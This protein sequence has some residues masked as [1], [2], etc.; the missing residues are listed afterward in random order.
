MCKRLMSVIIAAT[1]VFTTL[2]VFNVGAAPAEYEPGTGSAGK[3]DVL[4]EQAGSYP[5]DFADSSDNVYVQ[6]NTSV[7]LENLTAGLSSVSWARQQGAI[8]NSQLILFWGDDVYAYSD[9]Y[10]LMLVFTLKQD[11]SY[12]E[13]WKYETDIV[14]GTTKE[15]WDQKILLS[16]RKLNSRLENSGLVLKTGID[17]TDPTKFDFEI[18]G[19]VIQVNVADIKR[20]NTTDQNNGVISNF[21]AAY[22]GV[23]GWGESDANP[24]EFTLKSIVDKNMGFYNEKP[25]AVSGRSAGM[26]R[27]SSTGTMQDMGTAGFKFTLVGRQRY[28]N[29]AYAPVR[30]MNGTTYTITNIVPSREATSEVSGQSAVMSIG[31]MAGKWGEDTISARVSKAKLSVVSQKAGMAEV[32]EG[33]AD[34]DVPLTDNAEIKTSLDVDGNLVISVGNKSVSV[35][36]ARLTELGINPAGA[37]LSFGMN[38]TTGLTCS[39]N[40]NVI[41]M[42]AGGFVPTADKYLIYPPAPGEILGQY[43]NGAG[44]TETVNGTPI[45]ASDSRVASKSTY[46]FDDFSM[47]I[48]NIDYLTSDSIMVCFGLVANAWCDRQ[49]VMLSFGRDGNVVVYTGVPG[50][51]AWDRPIKTVSGFDFSGGFIEFSIKLSGESYIFT[52]N[53]RTFTIPVSAFDDV[54]TNQSTEHPGFNPAACRLVFGFTSGKPASYNIRNIT[55]G[56][57]GSTGGFVQPITAGGFTPSVI[58]SKNVPSDNEIQRAQWYNET[59]VAVT[60]EA[61]GTKLDIISGRAGTVHTFNMND[62]SCIINGISFPDGGAAT[63]AIVSGFV[64]NKDAGYD[65]AAFLLRFNKNGVLELLCGRELSFPK[66]PVLSYSGFDFTSV[67]EFGMKLNGDIYTLTVNGYDIEF[68][69]FVLNG[70]VTGTAPVLNPQAA[71]LLFMKTTTDA[72]AKVSFNVANFTGGQPGSTGFVGK[73]GPFTPTDPSAFTN[74]PAD[75]E[76][77]P[78]WNANI[79]VDALSSGTTLTFV[80]GN[81][82]TGSEHT[83]NINDFSMAIRNITWSAGAVDNDAIMIGFGVS[84]TSGYDTAS[85]LL[86]FTKGGQV[87]ISAGA[88]AGQIPAAFKTVSGFDFSGGVVEFSIKLSGS[89]YI[90]IVNGFEM[91]FDKTEFAVVMSDVMPLNPEA[92]YIFCMGFKAGTSF[93]ICNITGGQPGSTGGFELYPDPVQ[94]QNPFVPTPESGMTNKPAAGDILRPDFI[95]AEM[96]KIDGNIVTFTTLGGSRTGSSYDYNCNDFSIIFDNLVYGAEAGTNPAV[97]VGISGSSGGWTDSPG[98]FLHL[99]K[100]GRIVFYKSANT[101]NQPKKFRTDARLTGTMLDS[102][103]ELAL[104]LNGSTYTL[105]I[106]GWTVDFDKSLIADVLAAGLDMTRANVSLGVS[107]KDMSFTVANFTGKNTALLDLPDDNFTPTDKAGLQNHP[108]EG[109]IEV[110]YSTGIEV[111]TPSKSGTRLTFMDATPASSRAGTK[112]TYNMNELHLV[113]NKIEYETNRT[114]I[115]VAVTA[116]PNGWTDAYTIRFLFSRDGKVTVSK[117]HPAGVGGNKTIIDQYQLDTNFG[118]I[119]EFRFKLVGNEY[120]MTANGQTLKIPKADLDSTIFTPDGLDMTSAYLS[121][122]VSGQLGN[123]SYNIF[124]ITGGGPDATS[125]FEGEDIEDDEEEEETPKA[126]AGNTQEEDDGDDGAAAGNTGENAGNTGNETIGD[127]DNDG[128]VAGAQTVEEP[129]RTIIRKTN[130]MAVYIIMGVV[131]LAAVGAAVV[132]ILKFGRKP[133]PEAAPTAG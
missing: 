99:Y 1:L 30:S 76:H 3:V 69:A 130:Y 105:S 75:G 89:E 109:E 119:L 2:F 50:H 124:N 113:I 6:K 73:P 112:S 15:P 96:L 114:G 92:A 86:R 84:K 32:A 5:L 17:A 65:N 23:S 128:N 44:P 63:D 48:N 52:V 125:N 85:F 26:S 29:N 57:T 127:G 34:F 94:V 9:A 36:N 40:L 27:I 43:G 42:P 108:A 72:S 18:N 12:A 24:I 13:I 122:G 68:P 38:G 91:K 53:S 49:S 111:G 61:T 4:A 131:A 33:S 120:V 16:S 47:V 66:N 101:S 14:S 11:G 97:I 81:G 7:R 58:Y 106:N 74:P 77:L 35:L 107:P 39:Y 133:K 104:K 82:R 41:D 54:K 20:P 62:M 37:Y 31:G 21:D 64:V 115:A 70:M 129:G 118:E 19:E 59:Q 28:V 126:P 83:Y 10:S 123:I 121:F 103:I 88:N 60:P 56:A 25:D 80:A 71:N 78:R 132:L 46:N 100:D 90:L 93:E 79:G 102:R 55:G 22:F 95:S 45:G 110:R 87:M 51:A 67:I 98:L 8:K 117:Y 116:A